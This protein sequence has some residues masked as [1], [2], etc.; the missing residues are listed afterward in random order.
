ASFKSP[1]RTCAS[2]SAASRPATQPST[3]KPSACSAF[4]LKPS[5]RSRDLLE[6]PID[7]REHLPPHPLVSV[8]T[9]ERF[10]D[11]L[12]LPDSPRSLRPRPAASGRL[13]P[14]SRRCLPTATTASRPELHRRAMA[15]SHPRTRV[16][17]PPR[18]SAPPSSLLSSALHE[19][20]WVDPEVADDGVPD[21]LDR[22]VED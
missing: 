6:R 12:H 13:P 3:K 22:R 16:P 11:V 8:H 10:L 19:K 7:I 15:C 18:R 21:L 2:F 9:L 1:T 4:D 14:G 17:G 5:P 20:G